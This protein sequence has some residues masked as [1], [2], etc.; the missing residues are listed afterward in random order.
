MT[1]RSVAAAAAIALLTLSGRA[2]AQSVSDVLGNFGLLGTWA[3]DCRHP[4]SAFIPFSTFAPTADGTVVRTLRRGDDSD[5]SGDFVIPWARRIAPDQVAMRMEGRDVTYD[6][7]IQIEDGQFRAY[8]ST[9][10]DGQVVVRDGIVLIDHQPAIWQKKCR[11]D[12]AGLR[13]MPAPATL[14]S[15]AK[16]AS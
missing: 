10:A 12:M 14:G 3:S 8:Q 2:Q 4:P 1:L 13:S 15:P 9:T 11:E 16:T 6:I 5:H 7:I